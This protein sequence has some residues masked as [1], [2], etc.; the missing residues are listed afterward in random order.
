MS[1]SDQ[2]PPIHRST[3][4]TVAERYLKQLCEKTF[5]SL[6]SYP[7]LYRNQGQHGGKGEGKEVCDLLVVFGN[8]VLIFS[9]KDCDY[10]ATGEPKVDWCRWFRKAILKSA[11]QIWGAER[12]IKQ[13]PDDLFLDRACTQPF[14]I[15]LPD[16]STARFHRIVV[17]HKVA[18]RCRQ[19]MGGS[20]SLTIDSRIRGKEHDHDSQADIRPFCIGHIDPSK[21]FVHVLDDVTLDLVLRTLDTI[22]DF[23]SYLN[24]KEK[25][26]CESDRPIIVAGEENL[27]PL[28]LME[29][30]AEGQLQ[31]MIP[32]PPSFGGHIFAADIWP[33]FQ[34]SAQWQ[35]YSNTMRISY[36][37]DDLI[38][39]FNEFLLQGKSYLPESLDI[40][41]H[42]RILRFLASEPRRRRL[43]LARVLVEF[44]GQ[45]P[46]RVRA[47]RVIRSVKEGYPTY[48]FFLYPYT[49]NRSYDEYRA[50]R[51]R[52]LGDYCVVE[53]HQYPKNVDI[54][55]IA[56]ETGK[57]STR[58]YEIIYLDTR[59]WTTEQDNSAQKMEMALRE[60]GFLNDR[61][62]R[63][64]WGKRINAELQ[65]PDVTHKK[66]SRNAKCF[67]GSGEK[68]KHCHG[69]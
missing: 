35:T 22:T 64:T 56:T 10:P 69:R 39:T 9:D 65:D 44:L 8:D 48:L 41:Y 28:Y 4:I 30:A 14:P 43:F 46:K 58:T 53:K 12:W 62:A 2:L 11:E 40:N 1:E 23:V 21:G 42:E 7:G 57:T 20:G 36:A 27:L 52:L 54:I 24:R 15:Q 50:E 19:E 6:W 61:E 49:S 60:A 17:A 51:K 33:N 29:V 31:F 67:C 63:G 59:E 68:Y 25:L 26:I 45:T 47:T 5:L 16:P 18:E 55:G 13:H 3:G 32:P 37:W 38:E 34:R 66:I